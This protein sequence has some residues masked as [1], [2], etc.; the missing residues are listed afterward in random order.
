MKNLKFLS[1]L[2]LLSILFVRCNKTE[3]KP[4]NAGKIP[5]Q[6]SNT[7]TQIQTRPTGGA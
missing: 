4:K 7:S 3:I 6:S 5:Q 1:A 2:L